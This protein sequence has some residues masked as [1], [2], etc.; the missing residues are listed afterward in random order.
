[1]CT[2]SRQ[3]QK[4]CVRAQTSCAYIADVMGADFRLGASWTVTCVFWAS[5]A[6]TFLVMSHRAVRA[7]RIFVCCSLMKMVAEATRLEVSVGRGILSPLVTPVCSLKLRA[8]LQT[9]IQRGG[10]AGMSTG[11]VEAYRFLVMLL[12]PWADW[13]T[14]VCAYVAFCAHAASLLRVESAQDANHVNGVFD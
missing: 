3:K 11:R 6:T 1:M 4:R 10:D 9:V 12:M 5:S 8:G 7:V 2:G 14:A 13:S